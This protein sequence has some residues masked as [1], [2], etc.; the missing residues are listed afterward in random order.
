MRQQTAHS[1]PACPSDQ[2]RNVQ[3][4]TGVGGENPFRCGLG[5]E[6]AGRR[7]K[8]AAVRIRAAPL[9]SVSSL[10]TLLFARDGVGASPLS[11]AVQQLAF[12]QHSQPCEAVLGTAHPWVENGIPII[13]IANAMTRRAGPVFFI[14]IGTEFSIGKHSE[15]DR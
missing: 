14:R 9:W 5:S 1:E 11:C 4:R 13:E 3:R 7:R 15:P 2:I 6:F 10:P 12:A 8:S